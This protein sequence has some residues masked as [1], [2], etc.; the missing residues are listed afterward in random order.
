MRLLQ[1]SST[2][3]FRLTKD[4]IGDETIP[5]YAILSHTWEA[6]TEVTFADMANGTSTDKFG[7]RKIQFCGEQAKQDDLQYFWIDTCC[8][9]KSNH[10]E[11]QEAINS[12]FRWYQNA[13]KCY[14]YL[15][16]VSTAKPN[17]Y[18][19]SG[20]TWELSFRKS[21]W[22]TRGWTLQ[23]LLAP[24]L[25]EF[26]SQE[27]TRLGDKKSLERQIH[28]ITG[29]ATLALQGAPLE[30]FDVEERLSWA[31]SRRTTR[32]EDRAYSLLG[33]FGIYMPLIYGEGEDNA[34]RRLQEEINKPLNGRQ[35]KMDS[36]SIVDASTT[37]IRLIDTTSISISSFIRSVRESRPDLNIVENELQSIKRTLEL[38]REDLDM[39]SGSEAS[40]AL[41]ISFK[42]QI[43]GIIDCCAATIKQIQESLENS[44]SL[45]AKSVVGQARW[46]TNGKIDIQRHRSVLESNR[47]A[48]EIAVDLLSWTMT[49]EVKDTTVVRDDTS[50][51]KQDTV[52]ILEEIAR[53]QEQLPRDL[54]QP[55]DERGLVLDRYLESLTSYTETLNAEMDA[56]WDSNS[57]DHLYHLSRSDGDALPNDPVISQPSQAQLPL[58]PLSNQ[59]HGGASESLQKMGFTD[60]HSTLPKSF[61]LAVNNRIS[62][63]QFLQ[64]RTGNLPFKKSAPL[65]TI[66][67]FLF[68]GTLR[69]VTQRRSLS[70]IAQNM[71]PAVLRGYQRR[72][73]KGV[74]YPALIPSIDP[75]VETTGM[76]IFGLN[77]PD[78]KAMDAFQGGMYDLSRVTVEI[79]LEDGTKEFP[80]ALA[81]V[82]NGPSTGLVPVEDTSWSPLDM[83]HD[84]WLSGILKM[85][86][87]EEEAL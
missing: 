50:H 67:A 32:K 2:G 62:R 76:M 25:V 82:W 51:I 23:E 73:V 69:V 26:F 24:R 39:A 48:L 79:E 21:R 6:D 63:D 74:A 38:L 80:E 53:L 18:E 81:F 14:V 56:E 10:V 20:S 86:E 58:H 60:Q 8:I 27:G 71:T 15:S 46:A 33:I 72:A 30:E 28:E 22:F 7:Y 4:L 59:A 49:R 29:I 43:L 57:N 54:T 3:D 47:R 55:N 66:G 16:D 85:V 70:D 31:K 52:R 64:L 5:P 84:R 41:P 45:L 42:K 34:F 75:N 65:L 40:P 19:F 77:G 68:P 44:R 17:T 9:D 12:M 36:L 35:R 87:H 61:L 37:T 1:R 78:R 13:V 11:L 83:L